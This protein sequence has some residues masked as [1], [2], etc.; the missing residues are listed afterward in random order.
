MLFESPAVYINKNTTFALV[1][2][3]KVTMWF[4]NIMWLSQNPAHITKTTLIF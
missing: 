2:T 4:F 1:C 3:G